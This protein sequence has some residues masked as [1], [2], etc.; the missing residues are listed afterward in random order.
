MAPSE[1][2]SQHLCFARGKRQLG[3]SNDD[4][5]PLSMRSDTLPEVVSRAQ[6]SSVIEMVLLLAPRFDEES[7]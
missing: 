3:I 5:R 2:M 1:I 6:F 7:W 4:I